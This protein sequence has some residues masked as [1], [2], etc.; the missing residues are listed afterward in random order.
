MNVY[1]FDGTIYD[2]D[3]TVDF[4]LWALKACPSLVRYLPAQLGGGLLYAAKR[5]DKTT[6]KEHFFRF[7]GGIDAAA[8]A[9][10]FWDARQ[11]RIFSWY[12]ARRAPGDVVISASPAFLLA[13]ICTRL[14]VSHLI[15]SQVDC[16]TGRF[17]GP[18]CRGSEKVRRFEQA[19]G[20]APIDEF[21][22]D[23][24]ADLPLARL[25]GRA[26]LVKGGHPIPWELR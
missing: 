8:M 16:R 25:A 9:E 19:F 4:F 14:G 22:S 1:D 12:L 11:N 26:F 13:P 10:A 21:Y 20:H 7:L 23:S 15:A 17:E 18:N 6:L 3:S 2:G 24:A 5:I